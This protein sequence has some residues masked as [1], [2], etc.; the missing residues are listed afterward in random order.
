MKFHHI[1]FQGLKQIHWLLEN[2]GQ[3]MSKADL[4]GLENQFWRFADLIKLFWRSSIFEV[5][6]VSMELSKLSKTW[7]QITK[8]IDSSTLSVE[9]SKSVRL[10]LLSPDIDSWTKKIRKVQMFYVCLMN[11]VATVA[12]FISWFT[13]HSVFA[14]LLNSDCGVKRVN[15]LTNI[16]FYQFSTA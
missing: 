1:V 6:R 4:A 8:S 15:L 9:I 16:K 13:R 3:P 7:L 10:C 11:P 2:D 5:I 14:V 12:L